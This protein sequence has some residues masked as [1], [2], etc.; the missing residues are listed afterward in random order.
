MRSFFWSSGHLGWYF[1]AALVFSVLCLLLTDVIWRLVR[2][3]S[4][5]LLSA[6]ALVWLAGVAALLA[7]WYV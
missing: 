4:R 7:G 2:T 5:K 1:F 6:M 3:S